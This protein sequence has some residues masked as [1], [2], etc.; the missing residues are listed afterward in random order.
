MALNPNAVYLATGR[1]SY[2]CSALSGDYPHTG[3]TEIGTVSS[4]DFRPVFLNAPVRR[5]E[6]NGVDEVLY[7]GGEVVL[8]CVLEE[9][10]Q[11]SLAKLFP[12]STT[13]TQE[14]L[15]FPGSTLTAGAPMSTTALE[16]LVFT[17][18]NSDHPAIVI[19]KAI[20]VLE[21]NQAMRFSATSHLRV[22]VMFYGVPDASGRV[23]EVG[24][25]A[26]L[27]AL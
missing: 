11:D 26:N 18:H 13:N 24:P 25:F 3:G 19:Y 2:G 9:W 5:E 27:T 10:K 12:N 8:G 16:P 6:D 23:A 20:P 22:P 15:Q 17:P 7:L 21:V 4:I 1:L 14:I